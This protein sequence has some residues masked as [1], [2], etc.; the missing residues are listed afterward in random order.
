MNVPRRMTVGILAALPFLPTATAR[1]ETRGPAAIVE[2][3]EAGYAAEKAGLQ[4]GDE[5]LS[6]SRAASSAADLDQSGRIQSPY[7]LT[8]V[9]FEQTH[10]GTVILSGLRGARQTTWT[11][12][13]GSWWRITTRPDLPSEAAALYRDGKEK[14]AAGD[15]PG[16]EAL[17][18]T[19]ATDLAAA[20]DRLRAAW[21]LE[22]SA[23]KLAQAGKWTAADAAYEAA[24]AT[25][26]TEADP[27]AAVWI[28][29]SWGKSA[30]NQSAW[31]RAASCLTRALTLRRK[32]VPRSLTEAHILVYLGDTA[33]LRGELATAE[34]FHRQAME[35]YED[36]APESLNVASLL[37]NWASVLVERGDLNQAEADF[38]RADEIM[39]RLDPGA[40]LH[41]LIFANLGAV[42]YFRSDLAE[43]E[44]LFRQALTIYEKQKPDG[45][46]VL[47]ALN[48]LG[49]VAHMRGDLAASEDLLL[50]SL[51]LVEK[52]GDNRLELVDVLGNLGQV[53][54]DRGDLDVAET[55]F[56]RALEIAEAQV[57]GSPKLAE[58]LA[59]FAALA[60][61]RGNYSSARDTLRRALAIQE[62]QAP[63]SFHV[64]EALLQIAAVE[65]A[66]GENL[67]AA[68]EGFRRAR[69]LLEDQVP[70]SPALAEALRGLGEL[71]ARRGQLQQAIE[72]YRQ[73][74][75]Q[76]EKTGVG[77][78]VHAEL[79]HVLG[80]AEL[81][82]GLAGEGLRHLCAAFDVLDR[83]RR[84]LGGTEEV[85]AT[86]E[87]STREIYYGCLE[88]LLTAG[89]PAEA[90]ATLERGRARSFLDL[91][92]ERDLEIPGLAPE[93]A[94]ERRRIDT[95]YDR[96]QAELLAPASAAPPGTVEEL[97]GKLRDLRA[98][99]EQLAARIRRES[100]R[101]ASLRYPEPLAV[102]G[103]RAALDPGTVLLSYSVGP[104][105]SF[106][107]VVQ[108]A[109]SGEPGLSV[110]SLPI[111]GSALREEVESFRRLLNRLGSDRK[112]LQAQARHLY[113]LLVRPA[114]RQITNATRL[115]VSP[116]GPLHTLPFAALMRRSRYLAEWKPIHSVLSATVYT[117]IKRSR[118][119]K[120]GPAQERLAAFGDPL[121]PKSTQDASADPEVREALRRGAA[122]EPLPA[123]RA[124]VESIV[125]LYPQAQSYLGREATEEKAKSIGLESRLVHFACHGLLDERFPLNSALALTIPEHP[126]A[127]Q[128]NG[129]LQAW[130]I[131]ESVRL[132]ADL[133]TLSACDTALGKEMG[134]EGL[135]GL[136][137]A[138]QFAGARSVLASLWSI[139]DTS[140]AHFMQRFYG[141]LRSGKTKDEALR[142]AQIDQIRG[143]AGSSHPYHW[144]AFELFGDWR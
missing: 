113:D 50:R 130:E 41:G 26:G 99:Q 47:N 115:L 11:L 100:P 30:T 141:Y 10:R 19:A 142:A 45:G 111:G 52:A 16:G 95:E 38:R 8:E 117:E 57:P 18:R 14:I 123:T 66:S 124:E 82:A 53:A 108:P 5:I 98:Q 84:K 86:F 29:F 15:L 101:F 87:A 112:A 133:V 118:P 24:L 121:Y 116:D 114:E 129:L 27:L 54:K 60:R 32:A 67:P 138:F 143:K 51:R 120:T 1:A 135:V 61:R 2:S 75:M 91:L 104:E 131:L 137:R 46:E 43:A 96:V 44:R 34:T 69:A 36:L 55:R 125:A 92:A 37:N 97:Q 71:A 77:T 9:E 90:F 89:R 4:P 33:W 3:V 72:L 13:R 48:N 58:A 17:W 79:L 94:A 59:S 102:D 73:A 134:G 65:L 74:L 31:D 56:R 132:D 63:G 42:M 12:P 107:F 93:T 128:D 110:H 28:L 68:E 109:A 122:L 40:F 105:R 83:Q 39:R 78:T 119:R 49:E 22:R 85:R 106:L 64:A 81:R 144:A 126:A 6:W 140:T 7:D 127:G 20:G 139:S 62:Q 76:M 70:G 103:A 23:D 80:R 136:T 21:L 25:L 35:I 88:A